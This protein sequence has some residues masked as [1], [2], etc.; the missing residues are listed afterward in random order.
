M[1]W[2]VTA[3]RARDVNIDRDYGKAQVA[4]SITLRRQAC[5]GSSEI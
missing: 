5:K 4:R 3:Y 1:K 2:V